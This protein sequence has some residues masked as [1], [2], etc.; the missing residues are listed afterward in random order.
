[1]IDLPRLTRR[2]VIASAA[3]LPLA[4]RAAPAGLGD[5]VKLSVGD[6]LPRF[7]LLKP[8]TRT[9]L[10][11][12]LRD[13][14]HVATD[15][16]QRE[17][18]FERIDGVE[19]L[20]I[21]QRWDG[22]GRE[23]SLVTRSSLFDIG[24]FRPDTHVRITKAQGKTLVEGFRFTPA[25]LVGL[26]DLP[27]NAHAALKIDFAEPMFNFE[28]DI[29]LLQTLPLARGYAVSI[30]F[31]HPVGGQPARY[32]WRVASEETLASPDGRGIPCWVIETDYKRPDQ[33]PARFWLAKGTQ[34][35]VK[36]ESI[37]PDGT[38]HRKTLL[39]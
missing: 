13:G 3:A 2:S 38:M 39:F 36:N 33:K 19:R 26:A 4:A 35:L 16:W 30:P 15:V 11:S 23:P 34:Q 20:R 6:P 31:F 7:S 22:T 10:R 1:M 8:G 32:V 14:A 24:S 18:R 27:A 21:V 37:A 17:V 9:Y 25:A 12:Q 28:A 29:E 5:P